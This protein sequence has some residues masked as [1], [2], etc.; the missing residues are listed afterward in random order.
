MS[1]LTHSPITNTKCNMCKLRLVVP[2]NTV[3]FFC[4]VKQFSFVNNAARC[5]TEG[6]LIVETS[7]VPNKLN[8]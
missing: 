1:V 6:L 7:E 5:N 4:D 3:A 8:K 2:C